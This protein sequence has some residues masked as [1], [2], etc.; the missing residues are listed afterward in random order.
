[1]GFNRLASCVCLMLAA[2]AVPSRANTCRGS[3]VCAFVASADI[4]FIGHP[5]YGDLGA[6]V[7]E[8][9]APIV[10]FQVEESFKGLANGVTTV[11]VES[12]DAS[13]REGRHRY[14]VFANRGMNS[15]EAIDYLFYKPRS[16][17][18]VRPMP[19]FFDRNNPPPLYITS[20]CTGLKLDDDGHELAGVRDE[21][22]FL[23]SLRNG[24]PL[25]QVYGRVLE[26]PFW[27]NTPVD[28]PMGGT[29]IKLRGGGKTYTTVASSKGIYAFDRLPVGQYRLQAEKRFLVF[30]PIPNPPVFTVKSNT[31]T[32]QDSRMTTTSE[33]TGHVYDVQGRALEGVP[34]G[35]V[36]TH[37]LDKFAINAT[38]GITSAD[39]AFTIKGVPELPV[40]VV[41]NRNGAYDRSYRSPTVPYSLDR[42][43]P[44]VFHLRAGERRTGL[45]FYVD[46]K[47]R[48]IKLR[49]LSTDRKTIAEVIVR[50][51]VFDGKL[52][53][54]GFK[55]QTDRNGIAILPCFEG[56]RYE[57]EALRPVFVADRRGRRKEKAQVWRT[58]IDRQKTN[59]L[60]T[61][62]HSQLINY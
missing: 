37:G 8:P 50:G 60:I 25:P 10:Q 15:P 35:A 51:E 48:K 43:K 4:I 32:V 62:A 9:R 49:I 12:F 13:Y 2:T 42:I 16:I 18:G 26:D 41:A 3:A 58:I 46:Q 61:L 31:C 34:V 22:S 47:L 56:L 1:M 44:E 33:I 5:L 24:M 39:G 38:E 17:Y 45:N 59:Q 40:Q 52:Y 29:T 11:W 36:P 7:A 55:T 14:L 30:N 21:I 6:E 28:M 20:A 19:K 54:Y 27:F 57:V 23:R 53:H